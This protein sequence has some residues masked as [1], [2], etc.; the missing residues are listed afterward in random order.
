MG[1]YENTLK[2]A[3]AVGASHANNEEMLALFCAGPLQTLCGAVSPAL[4]FQ[5]A[6][7]KNLTYSELAALAATDPMEVAELMWL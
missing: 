5:G 3:K 1:S 4:V 6:Q 7:A 2:A